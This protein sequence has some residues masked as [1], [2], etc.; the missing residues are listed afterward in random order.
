MKLKLQAAIAGTLCCFVH[1]TYDPQQWG[2]QVPCRRPHPLL[3]PYSGVLVFR[4]DSPG[5]KTAE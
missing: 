1:R 3:I 2:C 4:A 5:W